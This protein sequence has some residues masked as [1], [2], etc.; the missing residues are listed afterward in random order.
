MTIMIFFNL[1]LVCAVDTK[2]IDPDIPESWFSAPKLSSELNLDTFKQSP[3]LEEKVKSGDIPS[4]VERLPEDPPVIEPYAEIG[5]YGGTAVTWDTNLT[6]GFEAYNWMRVSGVRSTPNGQPVPFMIKDWEYSEDY[7]IFTLKLRKG[8]KWSDGESF[9]AD[10]YM[11]WWEH[12]A[13]NEILTPVSPENWDPSIEDV[14]K[15]N[16]WTVSIHYGKSAPNQHIAS[17][18]HGHMSPDAG[19]FPAHFMKQFHPDF[20]GKEQAEKIA[21]E[22]G[23]NNWSDYYQYMTESH[24]HPDLE[25]NRPVL[26]PFVPVERTVS[27]AIFE[28]NP[29]YPFVDTEGNQLP[30]IDRLRINYAE[31]G[32]MGVL[33]A[34]TGEATFKTWDTTAS[35]MPLYRKNEEVE[36]YRT[37]V[38]GTATTSC[39]Y[40]NHSHPDSDIKEIFQDVRFRRALS[41]AI[42]REDMNERIYYGLGN[43]RQTTVSPSNRRYREEFARAYADY[44]PDGARQLL[45][46]MG[47][48]DV[49]DNGFRERPDGEQFNPTLI[50]FDNTRS[51]EMELIKQDWADVGINIKI[52]LVSRDLWL[53][54]WGN[55]RDDLTAMGA[56]VAGEYFNQW[57]RMYWLA[58]VVIPEW[59]TWPGWA[60]WYVTRGERGVEPPDDVKELTKLAEKVV[61]STDPEESYDAGI[62]LLEAQAEN[63]WTIGTIGNPPTPIIVSNNMKNVPSRGLLGPDMQYWVPYHIEQFYLEN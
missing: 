4:V 21:N 28:R 58:P 35:D 47:M 43:P 29:Y 7:K 56:N 15:I 19:I 61:F 5:T 45:D 40:I 53:Q 16:D 54:R 34:V 57:R 17:P 11:Y 13:Q 23:F 8:L 26:S 42:D 14:V 49:D 12:V 25:H 6:G 9:G 37:H 41:L 24:N 44:D 46:E 36:N 18:L 31:D 33:K 63:L 30:Y 48:I 2:L 55:N 60:R 20:I 32:D 10:D 51:T 39:I 62:R 3:L 27:Y 38:Y 22:A 59:T 1:N 52:E 50:F